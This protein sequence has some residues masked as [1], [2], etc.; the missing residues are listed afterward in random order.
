MNVSVNLPPVAPSRQMKGRGSPLYPDEPKTLAE[1]F[2]QAAEKH[3]K[4]G[5]FDTGS[6][7]YDAC[8]NCHKRFDP[9]IRDAK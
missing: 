8:V 7:M 9:A 6:D 3:D 4:Q 5:V 2:L 1:L